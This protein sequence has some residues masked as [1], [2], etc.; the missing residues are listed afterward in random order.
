MSDREEL[1]AWLDECRRAVAGEMSSQPMRLPDG[2]RTF[3]RGVL[4]ADE[5]IRMFDDRRRPGRTTR[6][7]G[8]SD[9]GHTSEPTT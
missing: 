1:L 2:V 8:I 6:L 5:T 3:L 9:I 7:V 4:F